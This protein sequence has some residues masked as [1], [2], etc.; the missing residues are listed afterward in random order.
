MSPCV[1]LASKPFSIILTQ[2]S[3]AVTPSDSLITMAFKSPFPRTS[4]IR[5]PGISLNALRK[6]S[7]KRSAFSA[8]FHPEPLP[9]QP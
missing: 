5:L 9:K 4:L 3:Q 1:G 2:I 7:P 6:I 8:N